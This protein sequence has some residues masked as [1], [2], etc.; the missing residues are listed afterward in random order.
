MLYELPS[1]SEQQAKAVIFT[2]EQKEALNDL[3][4]TKPYFYLPEGQTLGLQKTRRRMTVY[5]A[6]YEEEEGTNRLWDF[7][8][9]RIEV[10]IWANPE[11]PEEFFIP[12]SFSQTA[13]QQDRLRDKEIEVLRKKPGLD[14]VT[15]IRPEVSEATEV[16]FTHFDKTDI[17][18]LGEAWVKNGLWR[19]I[20]TNTPTTK[21]GSFLAFVGAFFAGSGPNVYDRRRDGGGAFLGDAFWVVP[22]RTR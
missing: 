9:R 3:R 8:S 15:I 16:M 14:G 20:R 13:D 11:R 19:Y 22:N 4:E 1:V 5:P 12:H 7:P 6:G 10:A 17:R 21:S 2:D 18:L